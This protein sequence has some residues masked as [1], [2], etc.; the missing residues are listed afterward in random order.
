MTLCTEE[1]FESLPIYIEGQD[2]TPGTL[3]PKAQLLLVTDHEDGE[4]KVPPG[5][6][7]LRRLESL[8]LFGTVAAETIGN[9][10]ELR[11]LKE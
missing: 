11:A 8:V 4:I 5:M 3:L 1:L 9:I 6:G 7:L 10:G 2:L